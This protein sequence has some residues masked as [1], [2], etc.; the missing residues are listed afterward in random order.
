[1]PH[2]TIIQLTICKTEAEIVAQVN[3][4]WV[5]VLW[6]ICGTANNGTFIDLS[7]VLA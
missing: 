2:L 5:N 3:T 4:I 7:I 6:Q 1:M